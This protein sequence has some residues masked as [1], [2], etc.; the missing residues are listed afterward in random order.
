MLQLQSA[1]NMMPQ[2]QKKAGVEHS[3]MAMLSGSELVK[4]ASFVDFRD[5]SNFNDLIGGCLRLSEAVSGAMEA[6]EGRHL[7]PV[8]SLAFGGDHTISI[9]T[10]IAARRR[11]P[12]TRLVWIDAHPDVNT[13]HSSTSGKSGH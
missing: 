2:G 12:T 8:P 9:G 13:P 1:K 5:A 10:F 7:R 6:A 11:D 3:W 4:N